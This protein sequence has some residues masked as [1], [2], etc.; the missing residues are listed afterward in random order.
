MS[1]F[2]FLNLCKLSNG[3]I[4]AIGFSY[5]YLLVYFS[6]LFSAFHETLWRFN[7]TFTLIISPCSMTSSNEHT[8]ILSCAGSTDARTG[9][10]TAHLHSGPIEISAILINTAKVV[11][12][13]FH[14]LIKP[15]GNLRPMEVRRA[16]GLTRRDLRNAPPA[17][18]V[19]GRLAHFL[20]HH[21]GAQL[22]VTN[23]PGL[24]ALMARIREL[25]DLPIALVDMGDWELRRSYGFPATQCVCRGSHSGFT[26]PLQHTSSWFGVRCARKVAYLILRALR[27]SRP[28]EP[29]SLPTATS[30]A[31]PPPSHDMERLEQT[32]DEEPDNI[33]HVA[34][35]EI[36]S[37]EFPYQSSCSAET[38]D[39][40]GFEPIP[41]GHALPPYC[42]PPSS[43]PPPY[44]NAVLIRDVPTNAPTVPPS[45]PP[46]SYTSHSPAVPSPSSRHFS[47]VA[48]RPH[49][50]ALQTLR[51]HLERLGNDSPPL[52]DPSLFDPVSPD[53][54]TPLTLITLVLKSLLITYRHRSR[55]WSAF[56]EMLVDTITINS[57]T[58]F[59]PDSLVDPFPPKILIFSSEP[60][61]PFESPDILLL[62]FP[63]L[64]SNVNRNRFKQYFANVRNNHIFED[65]LIRAVA[66]IQPTPS[67][68]LP[69]LT[70]IFRHLHNVFHF[71]P[72]IYISHVPIREPYVLRQSL[73][74]TCDPLTFPSNPSGTQPFLDHL[75]LV[76]ISLAI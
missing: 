26:R 51:S 30:P 34:Q 45:D 64:S 39:S 62:H 20:Q 25:Q 32:T 43:P 5:C 49:R 31:P 4:P 40:E 21:G 55:A 1:Y 33:I 18:L 36:N 48:H 50:E 17:D 8:V 35:E 67:T 41:V 53:P 68:C 6:C 72:R 7:N 54:F 16:H 14:S 59:I 73:Y 29:P 44:S 13:E 22:A 74:L 76:S 65:N 52:F 12:G 38:S 60:H 70:P 24:R 3:P 66:L 15:T 23:H 10:V 56:I 63:R 61:L 28:V 75:H 47:S 37:L 57:W 19:W 11:V 42:Q 69:Y 58:L 27:A 2:L 46:P 9:L 71:L